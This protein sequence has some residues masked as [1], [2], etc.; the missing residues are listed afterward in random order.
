VN[1]KNNANPV[2]LG[3]LDDEQ[4]QQMIDRLQVTKWMD[5]GGKSP[6]Q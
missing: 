4:R 6:L 1:T 5:N 3:G 2:F